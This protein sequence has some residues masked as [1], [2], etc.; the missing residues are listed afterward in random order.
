[1]KVSG[2][3]VKSLL[4]QLETIVKF[5]FKTFEA[6]G[7]E[8]DHVSA[9]KV[10]DFGKHS[11]V[12]DCTSNIR[13]AEFL[14]SRKDLLVKLLSHL[15]D[16]HLDQLM[17]SLVKNFASVSIAPVANW[18]GFDSLESIQSLVASANNQESKVKVLHQLLCVDSL[19]DFKTCEDFAKSRKKDTE[20]KLLTAPITEMMKGFAKQ[21]ADSLASITKNTIMHCQ[22]RAFAKLATN[23]AE[24]V[25]KNLFLCFREID[26]KTIIKTLENDEISLPSVST[27]KRGEALKF[28]CSL[29]SLFKKFLVV[30]ESSSFWN[31]QDAFEDNVVFFDVQISDGN[32]NNLATIRKVGTVSDSMDKATE[33]SA[34]DRGE[35]GVD[36]A[37]SNGFTLGKTK[38]EER[39]EE[40]HR[41]REEKRAKSVF[42]ASESPSSSDNTCIGSLSEAEIIAKFLRSQG[43]VCNANTI[44][45]QQG[46]TFVGPVGIAPK[47]VDGIPWLA[48]PSD[49]TQ[50][51]AV[52]GS[53]PA[54]DE[55]TSEH[56]AAS[57]D[58]SATN[59]SQC[60]SQHQ[61]SSQSQASRD[62]SAF[63][64]SQSTSQSQATSQSQSF[65]SSQ[66]S[67]QKSPSSKS[68]FG[69]QTTSKKT[70]ATPKSSPKDVPS[71]FD[72][73]KKSSGAKKK[74]N[75]KPFSFSNL[76]QS[77]LKKEKNRNHKYLVVKSSRPIPNYAKSKFHII[78]SVNAMNDLAK[79]DD[80]YL[81]EFRSTIMNKCMA[82]GCVLFDCSEMKLEFGSN[83]RT[84]EKILTS[85]MLSMKIRQNP[86]S[87]N[88][89]FVIF[90]SYSKYQSIYNI[91]LDSENEDEAEKEA[92]EIVD[93]FHKIVKSPDWWTSYKIACYWQYV[94]GDDTE[95]CH[96]L[97]EICNKSAALAK[98]DKDEEV[99]FS[100]LKNGFD[101]VFRAAKG[102]SGLYKILIEDDNQSLS[103]DIG[104]NK[105]RTST[106]LKLDE[107]LIDGD[108]GYFSKTI[109]GEYKRD[110]LSY[111]F[112]DPDNSD[113]NLGVF[114]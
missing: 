27:M 63:G 38:F 85:E 78:V 54:Q 41:F 8:L 46:L 10:K 55:E 101:S 22:D 60:S 19:P 67:S 50:L 77:P 92:K 105:A 109:F 35:Y 15:D 17:S 49:S 61:A 114:F 48:L 100:Q 72:S 47:T 99:T 11:Y 5:Q 29:L 40:E 28:Y 80:K 4:E 23:F 18:V 84:T 56:Q 103:R 104:N 76:R 16:V 70:T 13:E 106:G 112:V 9:K 93:E 34:E 74:V 107:M 39:I 52:Q 91:E 42:T 25:R 96:V 3:H 97:E 32:V 75:S 53:T 87:M 21:G 2:S 14:S 20:Y 7:F 58:A 69:G 73:P 31:L 90:D 30:D 86:G 51:P 43:M 81:F 113:R 102:S 98:K 24:F 62:P 65:A 68:F 82:I 88:N 95:C 83:N 71:F 1:M 66:T 64:Q 57:Q 110:Y 33:E 12:M 44:Y 26:L 37:F 89:S 59:K 45:K 94:A 36:G 79:G 108:I 6:E 111:L